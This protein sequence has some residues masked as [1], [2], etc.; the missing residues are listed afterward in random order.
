MA[1]FLDTEMWGSGL[2][3]PRLPKVQ[4]Q[5]QTPHPPPPPPKKKKMQKK[6]RLRCLLA[7]PPEGRPVAGRMAKIAVLTWQTK[8]TAVEVTGP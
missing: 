4:T 5:T 3:N 1:Q 8:Q 7:G 2:S 6:Q